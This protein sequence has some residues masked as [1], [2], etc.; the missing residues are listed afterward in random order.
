MH[1]ITAKEFLRK[2]GPEGQ[3]LLFVT[4]F[5]LRF[6]VPAGVFFFLIFSCF[7]FLY[8][9][10]FTNKFF[11]LIL[12][13]SKQGKKKLHFIFFVSFPNQTN[14]TKKKIKFKKRLNLC[15][16]KF[17]ILL[18]ENKQTGNLFLRQPQDPEVCAHTFTNIP[19]HTYL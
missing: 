15:E 12:G 10:L 11:L 2:R 7:S 18:L 14:R 4:F 16:T 6:V 9:S 8:F 5:L 13:I 19:T 17:R 1:I 3:K